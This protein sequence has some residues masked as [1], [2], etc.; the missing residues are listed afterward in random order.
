M[1]SILG[2]KKMVLSL[3]KTLKN[4]TKQK[5]WWRNNNGELKKLKLEDF[6]YI[7]CISKDNIYF[8]KVKNAFRI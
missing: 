5:R 3:T 8:E 1:M 4:Q 7:I 2:M 6:K